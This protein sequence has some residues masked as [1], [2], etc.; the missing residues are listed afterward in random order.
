MGTFKNP[1]SQYDWMDGYA[2]ADTDADAEV[3]AGIA[4]AIVVVVVFG[5]GI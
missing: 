5:D 3:G 1:F 4:V 2:I